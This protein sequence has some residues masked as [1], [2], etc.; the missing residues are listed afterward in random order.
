MSRF[1][2]NSEGTK[3]VNLAGGESYKQTPELELVSILLTSFVNDQ[4]YRSANDT[5]EKLKSLV[6]IC[7]KKFVAQAAVYAR[8]Q[9]GM[10]SI[11]HVVASEL[12]KHISGEEWSKDFYKSII[13]RP[14]DMMEI[15]SYHKS[16][17]GKLPNSMKKGFAKAFDKFDRYQL[18]KYRGDG[19]DIKLVDIVNLVHPK[20]IEKNKDALNALVNGE[21]KSFDTWESELSKAGQ[22]SQN[23]EEKTEFKKE[24]WIKLIKENKLGY[25]A[26]LRN[27]RNIL[28]QAPEVIDDAI[29]ILTNEVIIKK[30]LVLPFRF[31]TA[32]DEINLMN[33]SKNVR[34]VLMALNKAVDISV[35]NVPRFDGDTLVV[36]DKSGSMSGKPAVIGSLFSAIIIKSNNADFMTF[37]DKAQYVNVNPM[38]TTI[39]ITN[40]LRFSNG[41]TNFKDIF[42]VANKKYDRVIILSDMQGWIGAYSP[43][44]EFNIYKKE[45]NTNPFIYSFDLNSYG[46]MQFPQTNV[47]CLTGFS[48]KV[49]D[50]MK[51]M[52]Q[53]K[54]ALVNEIKKVSF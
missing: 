30:S 52:E 43:V 23:D 34:N 37:S 54:N 14:D 9:F 28:E 11:T 3:T 7:D 31:I 1:N 20:P 36:L 49:F 4:F 47:F 40:S 10:R 22:I 6:A 17:N 41:G 12:A 46:S 48:E 19:K 38:D 15:I 39:T 45:Y 21:L 42:K 44:N 24:V 8:T 32:F 27:L 53:D 33:T 26:L 18:A 51:L 50:I 13:Y 16:K 25:F 5:F 29:A 2:Q 35:N